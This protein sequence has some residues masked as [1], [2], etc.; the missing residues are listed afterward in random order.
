M[1]ETGSAAASWGKARSSRSTA[2]PRWS[3]EAPERLAA[4]F[5]AIPHPKSIDE[6]PENG[7]VEAFGALPGGGYIAIGERQYDEEGNI[8]AWGWKGWQTT[9]FLL[10]R[11]GEYNVTDLV[12]TPK[13]DVLTLQ[14][15]K[16][17]AKA[18]YL[19]AYKGLED[20]NEYRRTVEAKLNALGVDPSVAKGDKP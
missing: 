15:K 19:S 17:Q 6:G 8:R 20:F 5:K 7:E 12:V 4:R 14:G 9:L 3:T 11:Y 10:K 16:D 1:R 18:E 13:G 2:A